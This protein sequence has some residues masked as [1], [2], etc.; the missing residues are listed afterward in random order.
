MREATPGFVSGCDRACEVGAVALF[1]V[2][3]PHRA[4]LDTISHRLSSI[5]NTLPYTQRTWL[6]IKLWRRFRV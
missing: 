6:S 3:S 1:F 5:I 4:S 2:M